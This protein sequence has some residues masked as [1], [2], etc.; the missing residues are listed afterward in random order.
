[1]P[2]RNGAF[3]HEPARLLLCVIC[4][5][6]SLSVRQRYSS[7][8]YERRA[9]IPNQNPPAKSTLDCQ[10]RCLAATH[11]GKES[12]LRK[13]WFA[14]KNMGNWK[15]YAPVWLPTPAMVADVELT[16]AAPLMLGPGYRAARLLV[17]VHGQPIGYV[18]IVAGPAEVID[19]DRVLAALDQA[20]VER[21]LDHVL[22]D[23]ESLSRANR[24]EPASLTTALDQL[25][26]LQVA[27]REQAPATGP[28]VSVAIC[29]RNRSESI[30]ATLAS[31][32]RQTYQDYEI[33]VVDNAPSDDATRRIVQA[34]YPD[35]RYILEPHPGLDRARNRAIH[36]A[37]GELLAY[38]DDDAI[39]DPRWL[40]SIV[41]AF[42]RPD[43]MCITGFVAPARL[44]T[45]AQELFERFGY[46]KGF[47]RLD[48]NL[49]APPP[50]PLF[51]YKGY[52]GTGCNSAFRRSVF[53]SIG[54]FDPRL[55]MGTPVPGG[56]DHDMFTRII[57]A[58]HTLRYEPSAVVY[59]DHIADLSVLPRKLGQYHQAFVAYLTK[60]ALADPS[61]A[62]PLFLDTLWSSIR[63]FWRGLAA[64]VIK[65]DRPLSMVFTQA[66]Y[67]FLGPVA[68]YRSH[69][70]YEADMSLPISDFPGASPAEL[71]QLELPAESSLLFDQMVSKD[72]SHEVINSAH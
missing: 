11:G 54:L 32:M 18:D 51:P 21:A 42:D 39:A 4:A 45:A 60:C 31:L 1:L 47:Y 72:H 30:G 50:E 6:V 7:E 36:E 71:A 40:E 66:F 3:I 57:R 12:R 33:L 70:Q 48:F 23:L 67:P 56:G 14:M 38:I 22:R 65:R 15:A 68:L 13:T 35:V 53:K 41:A 58:G 20:A 43:V 37:R 27:C 19:R 69:R 25:M 17:R 52:H 63:K 9:A 55:D 34:N 10:A 29:T 2:S 26:Q 5:S 59:H 46:S 28:L 8:S 24:P 49:H 61:K 62:L 16:C 64:V 44:D